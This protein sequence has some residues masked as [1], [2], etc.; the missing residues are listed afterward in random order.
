[1]NESSSSKEALRG[2]LPQHGWSVKATECHQRL[3]DKVRHQT[4][5]EVEVALQGHLHGFAFF[6]CDA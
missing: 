2:N 5:E 4:F 6:L 3:D 1:M